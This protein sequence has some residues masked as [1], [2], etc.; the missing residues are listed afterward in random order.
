MAALTIYRAQRNGNFTVMANY[1]LKDRALS[2]KAKGLFSV[3]LSLPD[4]WDFSLPGL[5]AICKEGMDAIRDAVKELESLGYITRSRVRNAKGRLESAVYA[6][7][8]QPQLADH[9]SQPVEDGQEPHASR[10]EEPVQA[11][12][13]EEKP[14]RENPTLVYPAQGNPPQINNP[15]YHI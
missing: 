12:P 5:A 10:Q 7:Y 9:A 2:L 8:E 14:V 3:L 6:L 11:Q 4:D 13:A 1:H 15:S